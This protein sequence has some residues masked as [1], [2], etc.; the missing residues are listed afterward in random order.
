MA[1]VARSLL[2]RGASLV[3]KS[4]KPLYGFP[5][6]RV[7]PRRCLDR[8]CGGHSERLAVTTM[9]TTSLIDD[10]LLYVGSRVGNVVLPFMKREKPLLDNLFSGLVGTGK[11]ERPPH[12]AIANL[13][14]QRCYFDRH[15]RHH[16]LHTYECHQDKIGRVR[17][18][19]IARSHDLRRMGLVGS[20]SLFGFSARFVA[21]TVALDT[22]CRIR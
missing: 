19:L 21:F 11:H 16:L 2:D 10:H 22:I 15:G 12:K 13:G 14:E 4:W 9:N 20:S 7:E 5:N 18:L 8:T 6:R 3:K 1:K 17:L